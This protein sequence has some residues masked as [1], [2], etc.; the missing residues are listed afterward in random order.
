MI[1]TEYYFAICA[2]DAKSTL[3]FTSKTG[4]FWGNFGVIQGTEMTKI[5]A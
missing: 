3:F 2:Y 5:D 4:R 1:F